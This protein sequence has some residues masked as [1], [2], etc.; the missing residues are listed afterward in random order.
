[1]SFGQLGIEGQRV[2]VGSE[3]LLGVAQLVIG[4]PQ[5]IVELGGA[6]IESERL[7]VSLDG[8]PVAAQLGTT[9]T[10]TGPSLRVV[11]A[12]PEE[13]LIISEDL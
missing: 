10:D 9:L 11:R 5:V 7:L 4:H 2:L 1:V 8:F 3:G 12:S 13:F 6:G